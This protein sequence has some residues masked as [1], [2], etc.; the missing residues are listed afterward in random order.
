MTEPREAPPVESRRMSGWLLCAGTIVVAAVPGAF[1]LAAL[2]IRRL[3]ASHPKIG[4]LHLPFLLVALALVLI[5]AS[6]VHEVTQSQF[7]WYRVGMVG[8]HLIISTS[9]WAL[10][11]YWYLSYDAQLLAPV[12]WK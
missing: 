10:A 8:M 4:D 6:A 9:L 5:L 12:F 3:E 2:M 1:V 7:V 11:M